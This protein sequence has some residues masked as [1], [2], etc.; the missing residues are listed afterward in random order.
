MEDEKKS[1]DSTQ[2]L[3]ESE[4]DA[5]QGGVDGVTLRGFGAF[6]VKHRSARTSSTR[7]NVETTWK[8]EKGEK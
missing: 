3:T 4:L 6:S 1:D 7:G 2:E 8:V 5:A